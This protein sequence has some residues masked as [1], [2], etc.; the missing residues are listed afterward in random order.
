[1]Q[2]VRAAVVGLGLAGY[3]LAQAGSGQGRFDKK[4]E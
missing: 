2:A 1:V 3:K 4:N